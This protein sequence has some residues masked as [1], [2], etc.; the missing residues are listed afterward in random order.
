MLILPARPK[1]AHKTYGRRGESTFRINIF[2]IIGSGQRGEFG[3][4]SPEL[5]L[6]TA[7]NN[8]EYIYTKIRFT[9]P[10]H[11]GVRVRREYC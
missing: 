6:L 2:E 11:V 1:S 4:Q 5:V 9:T 3:G 7:P 8:L 10:A